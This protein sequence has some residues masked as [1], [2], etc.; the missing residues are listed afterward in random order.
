MTRPQDPTEQRGAPSDGEEY[1]APARDDAPNARAPSEA[2]SAFEGLHVALIMD[3]NGR[4]A[5]ARGLPRV[6]GH[7]QGERSV[8]SVV[9]AGPDLG[10]GTLTLYAFSAD[11]W[12]RPPFEV[13]ELMRLFAEHL[14]SER[15]RCIDNGVRLNVIGRRDRL[16]D[17]L[18]ATIEEA[19]AATAHGTRLHLRIAVDYS[20]RDALV[21]AASDPRAQTGR[22]G[23]RLALNDAIHSSPAAPDVDLL[24]RT[25]GEQRLSDY[26]LWESAYAE[27]M[28]VETLWPDFDG[29]ALAACVQAFNRRER[30]FGG[31]SSVSGPAKPAV[32]GAV[33]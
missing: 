8:R 31:L 26:M 30:R 16:H 2:P 4:W 18:V 29:A 21:A 1:A 14:I 22:E 11:N 3:G 5:Q 24:V 19:E 15:D 12:R 20:A 33:A 27:L 28:F 7:R 17:E 25:S 32:A 9:E 13:G 6:F 23:F 10:V